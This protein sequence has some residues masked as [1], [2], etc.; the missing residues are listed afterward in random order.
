VILRIWHGWTAPED[1]EAYEEF[2]SGGNDPDYPGG[3]DDGDPNRTGGSDDGDPDRTGGS[4]GE[5]SELEAMTGEGYLGYDLAR[6][7][8]GDE[9]E[10]VTIL[11]F[12]D[13]DAVEAFAGPE[14]VQA[15]IPDE[16]RELLTR[17]DEEVSHY[18]RRGG[19][20]VE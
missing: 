17:W 5:Q 8:D 13:Y 20:R 15:H 12:E 19:E 10:F 6:R 18:E 4:D 9:V 16:A 3:S 2:L 1:A 14:Y 7:E 11:R